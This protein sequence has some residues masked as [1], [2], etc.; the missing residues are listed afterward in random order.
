MTV[1]WLNATE[2]PREAPPG[3]ALR[4][5]A[6]SGAARPRRRCTA[7]ALSPPVPCRA[8]APIPVELHQPPLNPLQVIE[9]VLASVWVPLETAG[10]VLVV[11]VFVLLEREAVRDRFIRIAGGTDLRATTLALNDAGE[12]LSRFFVSQ[13]AV[14]LGVGAALWIGLA[15]IGLPH[16]MLWAALAAVLRFV[17][18]VGI[19]IAALFATVLAAA[20]DPGWALAVVTLGLFV[21]VELVAGQLVEPQL[22]GHTTG[23]S[24]LSVIVA[25]IFLELALGPGRAHRFDAADVVSGG[26]GAAHQG[27]ES[28]GHHARRQPGADHAAAFLSTRALGRLR[29]DHRERP[30]LSQ[31]RFVCRLLRSRRDA[32]AAPRRARSCRTHHQR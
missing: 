9:K 14:N 30:R 8:A 5:A 11:L 23:L 25:A 16:A 7:A 4:A 27:V 6:G 29:R 22:F 12:R 10:I 21:G 19:W 15:I 17:P 18:Y 32:R 20:V 2:R 26:R 28:A 24:P 13:F 31:A 3:R 1:S